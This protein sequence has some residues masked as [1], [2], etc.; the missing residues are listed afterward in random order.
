MTVFGC[1]LGHEPPDS[2]KNKTTSSAEA[3]NSSN[4]EVSAG[5]SK[6]VMPEDCKTADGTPA[7]NDQEVQRDVLTP[8]TLQH[9]ACA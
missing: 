3:Y 2:H 6:H 4:L 8:V 7:N 5:T 9:K 1:D